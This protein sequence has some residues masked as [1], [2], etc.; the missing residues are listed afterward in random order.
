MSG[1]PPPDAT[2][3]EIEA[4]RRQQFADR[5]GPTLDRAL[6]AALFAPRCSACGKRCEK[7]NAALTQPT[8]IRFSTKFK[9]RVFWADERLCSSH[10]LRPATPQEVE[11]AKVA[12]ASRVAG[13]KLRAEMAEQERLGAA[14]RDAKGR[15]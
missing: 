13:E 12:I 11:S 1:F 15:A 7:G 5:F 9:G 6:D 8:R 3:A 14:L 4:W 10:S 2:R